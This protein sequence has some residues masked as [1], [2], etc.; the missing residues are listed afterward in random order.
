MY[1]AKRV[2]TVNGER[3]FPGDPVPE[4]AEWLRVESYLRARW[5]E[6]IEDAPALESKPVV[7]E[8]VAAPASATKKPK[9][10]AK[11]AASKTE[12]KV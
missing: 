2:M 11:K 7:K 12:S 6:E 1:I 8:P 4:A 10:V 9:P 3:R 5:I